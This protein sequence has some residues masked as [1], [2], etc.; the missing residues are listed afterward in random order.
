MLMEFAQGAVGRQK[1]EIL[2]VLCIKGVQKIRR[3]Y[4][5]L[6][7]LQSNRVP[8]RTTTTWTALLN[9]IYEKL[10]FTIQF[11]IVRQHQTTCFSIS[12]K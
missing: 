6:C 4:F 8:S 3:L 5:N 7:F 1:E 2:I 10:T 9:M 12:Q 11:G